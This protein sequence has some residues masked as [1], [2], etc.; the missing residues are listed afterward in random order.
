MI[1]M[2][3]SKSTFIEILEILENDG[4]INSFQF[5]KNENVIKV[6]SSKDDAIYHF[7]DNNNLINPQIFAI[8]RKI[9][10]LEKAKNNLE[11]QLKLLTNN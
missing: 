9:E 7:D 11:N 6:Y 2:N 8:Q 1:K 3:I 10:K 4:C 5:Y